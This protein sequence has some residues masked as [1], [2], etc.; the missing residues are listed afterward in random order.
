MSL[1]ADSSMVQTGPR[2]KFETF[3]DFLNLCASNP[4]AAIGLLARNNVE[5]SSGSDLVARFSKEVRR[6]R[7]DLRKNETGA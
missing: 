7:I 5:R 4:S 1:F 3:S 2:E 6:L